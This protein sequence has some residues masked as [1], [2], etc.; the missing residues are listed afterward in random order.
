MT[1]RAEVLGALS[2]VR[3]PELD[4]PITDLDFVSKLEVEGGSAFVRLRLPTYFCAPNFAYLMVADAKAA[5]LSVPGVERARVVLDDH[6]ASQ[7]I[8]G[9]VNDEH[10]FDGAFAGETEGP[11][12]EELRMV[13]RRKS[14]VS[15]QE[16]LCRELL[17]KDHTPSDLA[18]MTLAD[19]P[20]SGA[21]ETYLERRA[22]L[23]LDTSDGA[24][25]VVDPDGKPVPEEAVVQHLRFARTVRVSIEGNA[26]LC[27][28][29]LT[30]RYGLRET[31]E[32]ET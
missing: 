25:L 15:R 11:D 8:N 14:F 4:E 32:V 19:V 3:D 6:Y 23:V 18:R 1:S 24:P 10:G 16:Q 2:G 29:L 28:G 22:E 13:F 30:T 21:L 31:E 9:G 7:E 17:S 12:L 20:A 5:L 27:R 26:E